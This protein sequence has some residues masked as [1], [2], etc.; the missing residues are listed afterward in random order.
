MACT[1]AYCRVHI[2]DRP[3]TANVARPF[4]FYI[5]R[6]YGDEAIKTSADTPLQ[7]CF[8]AARG[9]GARRRSHG[10]RRS[11]RSLRTCAFSLLPII[12]GPCQNIIRTPRRA[13]SLAGHWIFSPRARRRRCCFCFRKTHKNNVGST[14][15]ATTAHDECADRPR[16]AALRCPAP[17]RVESISARGAARLRWL[18]R[19]RTPLGVADGWV[20][21]RHPGRPWMPRR[22]QKASPLLTSSSSTTAT[23]YRWPA[24]GLREFFLVFFF[25]RCVILR[26]IFSPLCSEESRARVR[27]CTDSIHSVYKDEKFEDDG[28]LHMG[29]RRFR[30]CMGTRFVC[31]NEKNPS[32]G[33][34]K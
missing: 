4:F 12:V 33:R 9:R 2:K 32:S 31:E 1:R 25:C 6:F 14:R 5:R 20:I 19:A 18:P 8:R 24:D 27:L 7:P 23:L 29:P 16:G 28:R 34:R 15:P 21:G 17:R 22:R 3:A 10:A 30:Y 26:I 11:N 13:R